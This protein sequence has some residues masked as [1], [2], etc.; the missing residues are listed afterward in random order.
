LKG[1]RGEAQKPGSY[2]WIK[3][4]DRQQLLAEAAQV[5]TVR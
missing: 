2:K 5:A 4:P 1:L 3:G